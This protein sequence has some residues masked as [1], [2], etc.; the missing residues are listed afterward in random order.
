MPRLTPSEL[1]AGQVE[2]L[3]S[4]AAFGGADAGRSLGQLVGNGVSIDAPRSALYA[5]DR[6]DELFAP[7]PTGVSVRFRAEGGARVRLLVQ[8]TTAG[9]SRMADALI[10]ERAGI[11]ILYKSALAEAANIVVSSY[12]SGVGAAVGMT[13]VPSVPEISVGRVAEAAAAAFGDLD[14]PLLLVTD[15]GL[16]QIPLAGRIVAA[17]ES[18]AVETLLATLGAL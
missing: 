4:L 16:K 9:A 1:S 11:A 8:F 10:G 3:K 6:L 18:E 13:L 5:R 7:E 12:L 15:F 14:A 17:P 2:A